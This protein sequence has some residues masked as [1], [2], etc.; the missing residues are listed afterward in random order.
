MLK[1]LKINAGSGQ[2]KF[3]GNGWVNIDINPKV[4]AGGGPDLVCDMRNMPFPNN[5]AD[6]VVSH[7]TIEHL[8]CGEADAFIKEA[9]RVLKPSGHLLIFIPD[10]KALA[11]RWLV[12]E[13]DDYIYFIN[14][15]GAYNGDPH[16][17]HLWNYSFESLRKMVYANGDWHGFERFNWRD[18]EGANL[19]RDWWI[20]G[21]DVTK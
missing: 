1:T 13:I 7:H 11:R 21:V 4:H 15:Y 20:L 17:R 2:R 19:A 8:G 12:G 6:V 10:A 14:M 18:I 9:H 5:S 16:D 3:V